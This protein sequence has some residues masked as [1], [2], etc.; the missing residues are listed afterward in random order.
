MNHGSILQDA[1][2]CFVID[3]EA[4]RL[5]D[6]QDTVREWGCRARRG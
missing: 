1:W 4:Q 6:L 2:T 3:A 5:R